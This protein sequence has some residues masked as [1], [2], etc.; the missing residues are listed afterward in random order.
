MDHACVQSN[1]SVFKK[2]EQLNVSS[3]NLNGKYFTCKKSNKKHE[4]RDKHKF[5]DCTKCTQNR[6]Q[7]I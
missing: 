3:F 2:F 7:K 5:S 1:L 4:E 6:L